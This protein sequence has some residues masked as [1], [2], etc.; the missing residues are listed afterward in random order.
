MPKTVITVRLDE[1]DLAELDRLAGNRKT[2]R[3]KLIGKITANF[4]RMDRIA[5]NASLN[6]K[7][8]EDD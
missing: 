8:I 3:S 5:Q 7:V 2:N 6:P 1:D 4:L